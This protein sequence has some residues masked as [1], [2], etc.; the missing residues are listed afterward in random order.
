VTLKADGTI[1]LHYVAYPQL[2]IRP[3]LHRIYRRGGQCGLPWAALQLRPCTWC[4]RAASDCPGPLYA[5]CLGASDM[6][7]LTVTSHCD[8]NGHLIWYLG[9]G[10]AEEGIKRDRLEQIRAARRELS[11][12]AA[13][14]G[15]VTIRWN[16]R[17]S[18]SSGPKPGKPG[19]ADQPDPACSAM[20]E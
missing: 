18:L 14:G 13:V 2:V 10:L 1:T 5:H 19:A 4:W 11:G 3:V 7:R 15:L 12:A 20:G 9:G 8:A 16:S 17:R 6:P